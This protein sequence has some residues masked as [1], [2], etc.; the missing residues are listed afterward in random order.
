[1]KTPAWSAA[2]RAKTREALATLSVLRAL[3]GRIAFKHMDGAFA[4]MLEEDL[5]A[6]RLAL[7]DRR[8]GIIIVFAD[9]DALVDAGWVID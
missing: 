2:Q 3:T 1:M 4:L 6:G 7:A 8:S 9:V 5:L